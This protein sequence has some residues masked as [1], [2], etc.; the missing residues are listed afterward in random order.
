MTKE[1]IERLCSRVQEGRHFSTSKKEYDIMDI[2]EVRV[3]VGNKV[4]V[5][6]CVD[7]TQ[8]AFEYPQI[9]LEVDLNPQNVSSIKS[10]ENPT[11]KNVIFNPPA[12]I[13]FWSDNTK[14]VVKAYGED[15]DPEKGFAIAISKKLLGNRYEY[16]NTFKHW[17]KRYHKD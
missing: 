14:T 7:W 4:Y 8:S 6:R 12:T 16:Y 3:V 2:A 17:L 15:Y 5:P 11:I 13:V 1:Q 10:P 9:E